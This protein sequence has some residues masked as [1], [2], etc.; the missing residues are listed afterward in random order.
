VVP[1]K[2]RKMVVWWIG[3]QKKYLARRKPVTFV[4]KGS[5]PEE[6]EEGN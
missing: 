1:E 4:T 3:W 2:G 5:F 6:M